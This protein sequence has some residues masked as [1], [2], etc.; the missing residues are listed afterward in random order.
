M[1]RYDPDDVKEIIIEIAK[2][3]GVSDQDAETL[4]DSLVDADI[5]GLS[6][7][8]VSQDSKGIN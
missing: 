5:H 8:G 7:H 3:A 4:A 1:K 2:A 6:T